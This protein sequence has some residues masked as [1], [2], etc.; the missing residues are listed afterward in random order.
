ML[1]IRSGLSAVLRH[2]PFLS[3]HGKIAL[4]KPLAAFARNEHFAVIT[5]RNG[6]KMLVRGKDHCGRILMYMG[7]L[8]PIITFA[9]QR[10]LKPGD[11]VLDIGANM[12][13]FSMTAAPIVGLSGSVH[14]FEPQPQ[15]VP[16]I[17]AS[18]TMNQFSQVHLHDYALSDS[19]GTAILHVLKGNSGAGRLKAETGK[20][21]EPVTVKLRHA[22][23]A[24]DS[25]CL[26]SVRML[27]IDVEGHEATVFESARETLTKTPPE[28]VIFESNPSI[29]SAELFD[30][31]AVKFL[32]EMGYRIFNLDHSATKPKI[33]QCKPSQHNAG[34]DFIALLNGEKGDRDL[35]ALLR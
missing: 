16:L 28:V 32:V 24:L 14:A 5:L 10:L 7:D 30:R 31:P 2:Y 27:K 34:L 21:W 6:A 18:V 8:E 1:A 29:D 9:A 33:T 23:Q 19:D 25:L 13:W 17:A 3:G 20:L 22:G 15:L 35:A 26:S 4:S 11:T 12:G